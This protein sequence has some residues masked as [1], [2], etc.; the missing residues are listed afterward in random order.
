MGNMR[1]QLR[2]S[3][4]HVSRLE[5]VLKDPPQIDP[6][7]LIRINSHGPMLKVQRP[8]VIEAEHMVDMTMGYQDRI[9]VP[10]SRPQRLL[11]K[12]ARC[13]YKYFDIAMLD[14]D[15]G[16]QPFVAWI[17]GQARLTVTSYGRNP[18]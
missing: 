11:A 1:Y 10:D 8:N 12:V 13:V 3:A 4:P 7:C 17:V 16:P 9:E 15:R 5:N 14:E 2:Q 18:G 6:S